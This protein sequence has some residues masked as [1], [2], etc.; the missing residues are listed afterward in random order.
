MLKTRLQCQLLWDSRDGHDGESVLIRGWRKSIAMSQQ[1]QLGV[2]KAIPHSG[3]ACKPERG[4][5]PIFLLP[6][7]RC[8]SPGK[9][10]PKDAGGEVGES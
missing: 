2:A 7:G 3:T 10:A 1:F 5:F 8:C 9:T 6:I 4:R